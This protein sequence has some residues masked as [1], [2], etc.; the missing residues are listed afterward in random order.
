MEDENESEV[1]S[2]VRKHNVSPEPQ[3]VKDTVQF[4]VPDSDEA[5]PTT[6]TRPTEELNSQQVC[7]VQKLS[8]LSKPPPT[9][10]S[11][12]LLQSAHKCDSEDSTTVSVLVWEKN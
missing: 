11:S 2:T 1:A 8:E 7:N 5:E 4:V 6:T 12:P 3:L 9:P 10:P